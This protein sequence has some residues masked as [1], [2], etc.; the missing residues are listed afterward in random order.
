MSIR[1]DWQPSTCPKFLTALV[2]SAS[3]ATSGHTRPPPSRDRACSATAAWSAALASVQVPANTAG[4]SP[5][6]DAASA[7][8]GV[9]L[10]GWIASRR[11]TALML[12]RAS[13][14]SSS[15]RSFERPVL[16]SAGVAP[17]FETLGSSIAFPTEG[18]FRPC[19]SRTWCPGVLVRSAKIGIKM[20]GCSDEVK[21]CHAPISLTTIAR[22]TA[23]S[24]CSGANPGRARPGR[25]RFVGSTRASRWRSGFVFSG[26][27]H[28]RRWVRWTSSRT[29]RCACRCRSARSIVRSQTRCRPS[30]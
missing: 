9:R 20:S 8:V 23:R 1:S 10:A 15:T 7:H 17:S 29:R 3:A 6:T 19:G 18:S 4:T 16:V 5:A 21:T 27:C 12:T 13:A 28:V 22:A 11:R 26:R 30:S 25:R 2:A 24:R 14:V